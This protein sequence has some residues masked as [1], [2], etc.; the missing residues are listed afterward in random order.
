MNFYSNLLSYLGA[1]LTPLEKGY[2][3]N[4]HRLHHR[5]R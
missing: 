1:S 5:E 3:S 4:T 2:A